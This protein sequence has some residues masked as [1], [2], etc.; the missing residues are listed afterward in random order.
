MKSPCRYPYVVIDNIVV[1]YMSPR[2]DSGTVQLRRIALARLHLRTPLQS[3]VGY[4]PDDK[5]PPNDE[6]SP[7]T[8]ALFSRSRSRQLIDSRML[9]TRESTVSDDPLSMILRLCN[10]RLCKINFAKRF[11]TLSFLK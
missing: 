11:L 1:A 2:F 7:G 6:A 8:A 9:V 5:T 3:V 10:S 4:F